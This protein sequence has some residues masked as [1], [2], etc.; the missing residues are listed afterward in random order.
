MW[1]YKIY[2][3]F[4]YAPL[5]EVNSKITCDIR[6]LRSHWHHISITDKDR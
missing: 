2:I 1:I 6:H 4:L 5:S 3:I